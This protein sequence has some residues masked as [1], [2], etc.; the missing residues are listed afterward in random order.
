M[1]QSSLKEELFHTVP[2]LAAQDYEDV[3]NSWVVLLGFSFALV[4]S[5]VAVS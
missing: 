3:D 2:H 5:F 4:Q 1:V